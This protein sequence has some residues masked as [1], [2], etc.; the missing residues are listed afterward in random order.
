MKE[1]SIEMRDAV[2]AIKTAILQSQ[3][4]VAQL[5]NKEL[6]SL[7]YSIGKYVSANTRKGTWGKG[8]VQSICDQ[9]HRELPGLRGFSPSA[10]KRMRTFY[11][12]WQML[13]FR[14]LPVGEI[15]DNVIAV[16]QLTLKPSQNV[17]W[18]WAIWIGKISLQ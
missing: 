12:Q 8:A 6:L 14:P 15:E 13:E 9:L 7:Y 11:E 4:N 2:K 1:I 18:R 5:A 10:V 17:H 16:D 3:Y